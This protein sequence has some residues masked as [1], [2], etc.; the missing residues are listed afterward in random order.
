MNPDRELAIEVRGGNIPSETSRLS[1]L[2]VCNVAAIVTYTSCPANF[3]INI[4]PG[5]FAFFIREVWTLRR[6]GHLDRGDCVTA[7]GGL[8]R[9]TSVLPEQPMFDLGPKTKALCVKMG[10]I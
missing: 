7:N 6:L 1:G 8:L 10:K 9:I 2:L 3:I 5:R 4:Q